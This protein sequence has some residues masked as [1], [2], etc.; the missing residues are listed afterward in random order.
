MRSP[1]ANRQATVLLCSQPPGYPKDLFETKKCCTKVTAVRV[2][3]RTVAQASE[4]IHGKKHRMPNSVFLEAPA[5]WFS[6]VPVHQILF[7]TGDEGS[8]RKTEMLL[9]APVL[10]KRLRYTIPIRQVRCLTLRPEHYINL[11]RIAL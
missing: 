4:T 1:V 7:V 8:R 10:M 2:D 3:H 6:P 5:T 11:P 9:N